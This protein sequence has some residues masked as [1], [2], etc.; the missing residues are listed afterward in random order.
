[1]KGLK[2]QNIYNTPSNTYSSENSFTETR[3]VKKESPSRLNNCNVGIDFYRRNPLPR[4]RCMNSSVEKDCSSLFSQNAVIR[5]DSIIND[6][7]KDNL[8]E[9][10][11]FKLNIMNNTL[12]PIKESEPNYIG[13]TYSPGEI[14]HSKITFAIM[15]RT[16]NVN[17]KQQEDNFYYLEIK[18]NASSWI[19]K[20]LTSEINNLML[21]PTSTVLT[22]VSHLENHLQICAI[23]QIQAFILTDIVESYDLKSD[24]LYLFTNTRILISVKILNKTMF[25]YRGKELF[26]IIKLANCDI[27]ALSESKEMSTKFVIFVDDT[28]TTLGCL[29]ENERNE[30][31][32]FIRKIIYGM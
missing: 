19:V 20:K 4:S 18:T 22:H 26:K 7:R 10:L 2:I 29:T 28:N 9:K 24:Y 14:I 30:W 6:K 1:M 25:M 27:F 16:L 3:S 13:R 15:H 23:N 8:T 21:K 32:R 5:E 12:N 17:L 31:V 11:N